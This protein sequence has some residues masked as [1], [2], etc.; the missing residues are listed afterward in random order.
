MFHTLL[1]V[2]QNTGIPEDVIQS[3]VSR[4]W[5]AAVENKGTVFL[6]AHQQYKLKFVHH[7]STTMALNEREVT[8][9][10]QVDHPPYCLANVPSILAEHCR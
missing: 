3:Y 9:V 5:L 8:T 1:G 10:L 2:A 4:G 7:L 6:H